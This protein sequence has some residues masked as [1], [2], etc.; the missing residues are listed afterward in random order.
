V[1]FLASYT[2][3]KTLDDVST[4]N[5][6]GSASQSTAG[7]NDLAQNPFD[8]K[9]ERGRSMF[10]ARHRFVVSYQWNLPWFSRPENWYGHI[11]GNWMVGW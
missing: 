10:D 2:Y 1:S 11:L 7:E 5:I 4:F 9:A 8:L 3:S 6:T